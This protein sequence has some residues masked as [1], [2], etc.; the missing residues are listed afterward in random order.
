MIDIKQ[1]REI[2]IRPALKLIKL[3]SPEAEELLLGT[4]LQESRLQYIKQ[5]GTGPALGVF[6]MEPRTHDD[7]WKNYLSYKPDLAKAV[8]KLSHSVNAQSLATDLLYAAA[9]SRVHYLRIPER[10]PAEGDIGGQAAYWK[11]YYN[12]YLGAGTEEEYLEVWK[13]YMGDEVI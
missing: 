12:T 11:Q 5:L 8:G 9:M 6:Q 7:I 1:F 3:Y 2:V 10:L 4:A 13:T